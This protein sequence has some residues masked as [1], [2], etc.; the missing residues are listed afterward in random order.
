MALVKDYGISTDDNLNFKVNF[1]I[2]DNCDFKLELFDK[3]YAVSVWLHKG[4]STPS[5]NFIGC[6]VDVL[7]IEDNV[8]VDFEQKLNGITTTKPKI[9]VADC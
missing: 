8:A 2:P 1:W 9:R 5:P 6:Q 7:A 3:T 4:H